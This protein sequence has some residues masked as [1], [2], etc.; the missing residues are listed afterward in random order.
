MAA[1]G[2]ALCWFCWPCALGCHPARLVWHLFA[3]I[4]EEECPERLRSQAWC[5]AICRGPLKLYRA[6]T[7]TSGPSDASA[8]VACVLGCRGQ[9]RVLMV[10]E[11][12]CSGWLEEYRQL[13][14]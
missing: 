5:P 8:S 14:E 7:Q 1:F 10:L 11:G 2:E 6:M 13:R 9:S 3:D 4:T 12:S